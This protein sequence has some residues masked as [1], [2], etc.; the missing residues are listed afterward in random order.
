M[1]GLFQESKEDC[2]NDAEQRHNMVPLNWLALEDCSNNNNKDN[3]RDSLLNDLELHQVEWATGFMITDT[4][5]WD[6]YAILEKREAPREQNNHKQRPI[7][8]RRIHLLQLE[9]AIPGK[10]HKDVGNYQ[11]QDGT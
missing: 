5:G 4:V 10:S 8:D 1:M 7:A 6:C 3:Q 9:I 2:G 11:H